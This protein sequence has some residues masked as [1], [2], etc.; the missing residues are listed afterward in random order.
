MVVNLERLYELN[1]ELNIRQFTGTNLVQL[2]WILP[3][4]MTGSKFQIANQRCILATGGNTGGYRL[5]AVFAKNFPDIL[6]TVCD[7]NL[8]VR[9]AI[10]S[11]LVWCYIP[12]LLWMSRFGKSE[13]FADEDILESLSS[14]KNRLAYWVM[15]L[16][17]VKLNK[18]SA[19]PFYLLSKVLAR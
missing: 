3:L 4:L 5:L 10:E 19:L 9:N 15:L 17:L 18:F 8:I 11:K 6:E 13:N 1:P 7:D 2:G 12:G 16:P 14:L